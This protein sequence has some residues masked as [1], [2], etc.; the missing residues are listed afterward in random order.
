M[1]TTEIV[2]S[3]LFF[4]KLNF[5]GIL[6]GGNLAHLSLS[7]KVKHKSFKVKQLSP[8]VS[9]VRL[10][11]ERDALNSLRGEFARAD[12]IYNL[13]M[14]HSLS[15]ILI[16]TC[17]RT[18]RISA[19][20]TTLRSA[21]QKLSERARRRNVL[22]DRFCYKIPVC[23]ARTETRAHANRCNGLNACLRARRWLHSARL[24]RHRSRAVSSRAGLIIN[25]SAHKR[26]T[27]DT[28]THSRAW[29]KHVAS[30]RRA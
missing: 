28:H 2:K 4:I 6:V 26:T 12:F 1:S 10:K 27:C 21:Q 9:D 16:G 22:S 15:H 30:A 8:P 20:H 24:H 29:R 14:D 7:I 23:H 18:R 17:A 5:S 13:Y 3:R 25:S 19:H 11:N